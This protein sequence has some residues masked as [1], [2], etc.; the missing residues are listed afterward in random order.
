[1]LVLYKSTRGKKLKGRLVLQSRNYK[2]GERKI[3]ISN[4]E[5]CHFLTECSTKIRHNFHLWTISHIRKYYFFH[6]LKDSYWLINSSF[7]YMNYTLHK[8]LK[9]IWTYTRHINKGCIKPT[10]YYYGLC[11]ISHYGYSNNFT[12]PR[13]EVYLT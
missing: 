4:C 7:Y 12:T 9:N 8:A 5:G 6:D 11:L 1:M 10:N 13:N 2:F 3:R